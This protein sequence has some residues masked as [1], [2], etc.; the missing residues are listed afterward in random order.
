MEKE[1]R[2]K[3]IGTIRTPYKESK[4]IPIQGQF[5]E[6]VTGTIELLPEYRA[7]LKDIEGFSH[8]VLI[9]Y[10]DRAKGEDLVGTP[11]L[12]DEE[13]GIFAIRSPHRPNHLGFSVVK[14]ISVD[15]TAITFS[16][17]DMLDNT[18][19]LDIKPYVEYFDAR[20]QVKNGWLEK[21]FADG[22]IPQRIKCA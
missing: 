5:D 4:G 14:L 1:I 6:S 13:H 22:T 10:F 16:G 3:P 7:G 12:E 8:L 18:P 9:Y 2:L 15:G 11:F 20:K 21:H 19:L 17:V